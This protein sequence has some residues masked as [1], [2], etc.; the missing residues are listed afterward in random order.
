M[1]RKLID[2]SGYGFTGKTIVSDFLKNSDKI[3]SFPNT[4]EFELFRVANGLFDLYFSL[5]YSWSLI[6]SSQQIKKFKELIYRIGP[7]RNIYDPSTY[8]AS[9][10]CYNSIF[11]DKFIS[12]SEEFI[13]ELIEFSDKAFWPYE[14][15]SNSK[16]QFIYNKLKRLAQKKH[17]KSTIHY[18]ERDNFLTVL[19]QYI[20]KLFDEIA[21]DHQTHFLLNNSFEPFNPEL[22]INIVNDSK[23]IIVD[24]DPRDIYGS[25]MSPDKVFFPSFEN[26][27]SIGLLKSSAHFKNVETFIKRYKILRKNSQ[28]TTNK[29]V[30]K[31]NFED[32]VL[33]N[34]NYSEKVMNFTGIKDIKLLTSSQLSDSKKN[35]GVWKHHRNTKEIMLIEKELKDYCH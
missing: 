2:V 16:I 34:V 7:V 26:S 4:F 30:L 31:I 18:S 6:R 8:F 9:G 14:N 22:G 20:Q 13:N 15:L 19:N 1:Q 28:T 27:K 5:C 10:H 21:S 3:L 12:I 17:I 33:D 32:F 35:I 24:R 29:N 11:N 23:L 25:L